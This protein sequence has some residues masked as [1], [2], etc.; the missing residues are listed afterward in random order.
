MA[1]H[2]T[3]VAQVP[4]ADYEAMRVIAR[5]EDRSVSSIVRVGVQLAL[6]ERGGRP[7]GDR[8][9]LE[10]ARAGATCDLR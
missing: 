6:A 1:K 3:V 5:R 4:A 2:H 7:H 8:D 10:D 9:G